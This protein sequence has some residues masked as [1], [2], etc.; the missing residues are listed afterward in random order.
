MRLFIYLDYNGDLKA[1]EEAKEVKNLCLI[2][3]LAMY[4]ILGLVPLHLT[5]PT[6]SQ[7]LGKGH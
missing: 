6:S 3:F 1:E 2:T 7:Y 4:N 5:H